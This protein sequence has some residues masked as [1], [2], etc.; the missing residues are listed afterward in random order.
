KYSRQPFMNNIFT[1]YDD[2]TEMADPMVDNE[3][4]LGFEAGYRFE[5]DNFQVNLNAY[6]TDWKNRFLS[7]GGSYDPNGDD[8]DPEFPNVSY[9]FTNIAQLH[10]GKFRSEEHTS[11]LQS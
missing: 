7:A 6:Y 8:D 3:E 1:N 11:E 9:L 10:K 4:I 2:E 5:T